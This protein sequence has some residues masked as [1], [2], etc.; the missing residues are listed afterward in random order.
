M[1]TRLGQACKNSSA[2]L[3]LDMEL[4]AERLANY[5]TDCSR[6]SAPIFH[7]L[8]RL[9]ATG[10]GQPVAR[11]SAPRIVWAE[12]R[13]P[14]RVRAPLTSRRRQPAAKPKLPPPPPLA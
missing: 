1:C 6:S 2:S 4:A 12:L 5:Q 11:Y 7:A 14:F 10:G 13:G 9:T 3:I 8:E